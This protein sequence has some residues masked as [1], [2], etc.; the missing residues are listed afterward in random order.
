MVQLKNLAR[1]NKKLRAKINEIKKKQQLQRINGS[2]TCFLEK[3]TNTDRPLAP[4]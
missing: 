4:N 1:N 2:K 3:I